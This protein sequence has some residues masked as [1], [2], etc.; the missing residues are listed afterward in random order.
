MNINIDAII[1]TPSIG[2]QLKVFGVHDDFT[3]P[4]TWYNQCVVT[5]QTNNTKLALTNNKNNPQSN[6]AHGHTIRTLAFIK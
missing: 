3:V 2:V 4:N 5:P 6:S 1:A